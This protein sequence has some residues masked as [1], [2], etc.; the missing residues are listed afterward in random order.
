MRFR[1]PLRRDEQGAAAIEMA[2]ALPVLLVMIYGIFQVGLV[3]QANAGMQHALGEGA[4]YATLCVP[5]GTG[6]NVPSDSAVVTRMQNKLFGMNIGS[7]GTPTVTTP[8]AATCVY[9]KDLSVTYS[10]TPNFL[11]FN[12]RAV[13]LTRSKRV[14][15]AH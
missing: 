9:C 13:S 15:I 2:I 8:A 7:F 6:C 11:F 3:F 4:R 14:Y 5:T 10:V 1:K 12:G